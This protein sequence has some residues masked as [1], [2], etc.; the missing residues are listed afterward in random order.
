MGYGNDYVPFILVA[1]DSR[2]DKFSKIQNLFHHIT[3]NGTTPEGLCFEAVM[4]DIIGYAKGSDAY[5][6]N[7]S[8]G[9][10]TFSNNDIYYEGED[11]YNHTAAQVKK[12]RQAGINVLSYFITEGYYGTDARA[13]KT[14]YGNDA[15]FI[16]ITELTPLAKSLNSKFEANLTI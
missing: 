7:F 13:F 14:M 6:I 15:Q 11:A 1:Y 8:D 9:C 3:A 2:K 5:F 16:N 12:I 10:P 4:K